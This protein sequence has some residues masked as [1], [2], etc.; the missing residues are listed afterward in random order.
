[1]AINIKNIEDAIQRKAYAVDSS[2]SVND[3]SD[4]VEAALL[5]TG[6]LREYADSA[7]LPTAATSNDKI[8]FVKDQKAIRFNNGKIWAGTASGEVTTPGPSGPSSP[9]YAGDNYGFSMGGG[10]SPYTQKVEAY[11]FATDGNSTD[12]GSFSNPSSTAVWSGMGGGTT[13]KGYHFGGSPLTPA[14]AHVYEFTYTA[15]TPVTTADAG[16]DISP[17]FWRYGHY[18]MVGNRT[19][20]YVAGGY[21]SPATNTNVI[22]KMPEA[23]VSTKT[24]VGNLTSARRFGA[25]HSSDVSS[26][27]SGGYTS[28][29]VNIIDKW[30][31]TADTDATDVGDLVQ[32]QR[33][34]GGTSSSTHGYAAGYIPNNNMI[35]KFPFASDANAADVANLNQ[36]IHYQSST[37]SD[38]SGYSAGGTSGPSAGR[39]NIQKYPFAADTDG[40]DVGDLTFAR[41]QNAGTHY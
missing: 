37:S 13:T 8:A 39:N 5:V 28:A 32:A 21:R 31:M 6:G 2:T 9:V 23:S 30:P 17:A 12:V 22:L 27:I 16:F 36:S 24:D 7:E 4:M 14:A 19:E 11:S 3:L 29:N 33:G 41:Q 25:G 26:Y 35:Q 40:T 1:M 20:M 10:S 38:V 18:E 34:H 15:G